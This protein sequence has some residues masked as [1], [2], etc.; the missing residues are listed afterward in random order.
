MVTTFSMLKRTVLL[1]LQGAPDHINV[2]ALRS[3]LCAIHGV[4]DVHDL[5]VWEISPGRSILTVHVGVCHGHSTD[6]VLHD[7]HRVS[8]AAGVTYA[9]VQV[10]RANEDDQLKCA[11]G[12]CFS[13]THHNSKNKRFVPSS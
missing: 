12:T 10:Q 13:P 4:C 5:H 1:L 11:A 6:D 7:A 8:D 2:D 9:T 3:K